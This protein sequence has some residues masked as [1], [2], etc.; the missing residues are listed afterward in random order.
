MEP[1]DPSL[2][3]PVVGSLDGIE[4]ARS[5]A[6][7]L[8]AV[9]KTG[10]LDTPPTEAL[11]RLTRLAAALIDAP[12]TFIS[13]VDADRDFYVSHSGFE[14]PLASTRE[15]RGS[16]F[17]HHALVSDGV[18]AIE[19]TRADPVYRTVA[20]VES[21]GVGAYLGVPLQGAD[22]QVVGSLCAIDFKPRAWSARDKE[23]L[24]ALAASALREMEL[25]A[26]I[27]THLRQADEARLAQVEAERAVQSRRDAL[28]AVAHD[29]RDPLNTIFL[30]LGMLKTVVT[31]DRA[32][33]PL[34][35]AQR[36]AVRMRGLLDDLL[37]VARI[38]GGNLRIEH[39]AIE[40]RALL[41]ELAG[42]SAAQAG[43]AGL[44][45]EVDAPDG[46]P[47][48][49]A[50]RAR[51]QQ[52][53]SNLVSNALKFTPRGGRV[54]LSAR[55]NGGLMRLSVTDTGC[56]IDPAQLPMIFTPFWQAD[57]AD[58]QGAG[59]GLHIVR[60]IV[61]AHGGEV[62]ASSEPGRGTTFEIDL[63]VERAAR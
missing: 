62:R 34:E 33:K 29:L 22:G 35:I 53:I 16:T 38:D 26:S 11:D 32:A 42:D 8:A 58:R 2:P 17:C 44:A 9:A 37:D 6:E 48:V 54:T 15:L 43:A 52:V 30:A 31:D 55:S 59:L 1:L 25:M 20:T 56:G 21:L 47:I 19:D 28:S 41:V 4:S 18:L 50:D 49:E 46:L 63:P 7:R 57:H 51:L 24:A 23:V 40:M 14:E 36:Q 45:L 61:V 60:G 3:S 12:A 5:S 27:G 39:E 13:L 10:L